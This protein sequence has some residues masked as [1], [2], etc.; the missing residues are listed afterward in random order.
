MLQLAH[1]D[2][3]SIGWCETDM[4]AGHPFVMGYGTEG[5]NSGVAIHRCRHMSNDTPWGAAGAA[6][7][8]HVKHGL[9]A[10]ERRGAVAVMFHVK[11]RREPDQH[12][13]PISRMGR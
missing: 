5:V 12:G 11:H 4:V 7:M 1:R 6:V 3:G 9:W 10:R 8:F 13:Q 2:D